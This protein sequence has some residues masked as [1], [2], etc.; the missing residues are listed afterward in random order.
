MILTLLTATGLLSA[1][2]NEQ[3]PPEAKTS[4]GETNPA[5][6]TVSLT[7]AQ[8]QMA[9]IAVDTIEMKNLTTAIS[10]NGVLAVPSQNK[11]F[12][13][14]LSGGVVRT[15]NVQPGDHVVKG[16]TIGTITNMEL[17]G[18][19]QQLSAT[20]AEAK[21]A[22]Q[23]RDRQKELVEGNAAPLK[24]LQRAEADLST[25]LTRQKALRHQ[26][27]ALGAHTGGDIS[28]VLTITAPISGAISEIYARIGSQV[29]ASE[30]I[31]GI[32]NNSELHLDLFVYEKDLPKVKPGQTIHFTLTNSP[33]KEYDAQIYSVGS[34]FVNETR[35]VPVHAHVIN[36]K[37]GLIEGMSVTARISLGT[38]L[39]PTVPD[40]AIVSFDGHD[41]I[42][43]RSRT[44][45]GET[46][47]ARV[48]VTK[49]TTDV[50]HTEIRPFTDLPGGVRVV[51][52][53]AFFL[54]AK[55]TNTGEEE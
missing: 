15:I 10:V 12:V 35:A 40:E 33:G 39:Y 55:M 25:L 20:E 42:F 22:T 24:N 19:Q 14:S 53:G 3:G 30:P 18:L 8:M 6:N 52:H 32:I 9:K 54:M 51:T 34:A 46:T 47:F 37:T 23:E 27:A 31:A 17:A 4:A 28:P 50:G 43:I 41:Y 5:N 7:D 36:D 49:G 11:A 2:N 48:Q 29:N 13:T 44:D 38:D 1:C 26:L 21:Y 45:S 16:Q